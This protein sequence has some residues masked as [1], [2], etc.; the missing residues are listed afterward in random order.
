M[1]TEAIKQAIVTKFKTISER[2]KVTPEKEHII[3]TWGLSYK[4]RGTEGFVNQLGVIERN[5]SEINITNGEVRQVKKPFYMTW[6]RALKKINT[7]L[8]NVEE[9]LDNEKVVKK[10]VV[11]ILTFPENLIK[12]LQNKQKP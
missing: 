4:H 8:G 5:G 12:K 2:A 7:M 1:K 11:N 3:P 10:R 9:N 6:N